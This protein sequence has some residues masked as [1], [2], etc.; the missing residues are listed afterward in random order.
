MKSVDSRG[1]GME[2]IASSAEY[3]VKLQEHLNE[4][5]EGTAFKGS[6]RCAQ[7]LQ[8]I[9]EQALQQ[10]FDCLKERM[11]GATIFGR[12]LSYDTGEDA[13]VR[14]TA[15]DVRK[16]LLQH[17]GKNGNASAFRI[18]LPLGTYIPEI[19]YIEAPLVVQEP[20]QRLN[21]TIEELKTPGVEEELS[22]KEEGS[23]K[24]SAADNGSGIRS[25][26]KLWFRLFLGSLVLLL[27][28]IL[29][30]VLPSFPRG[31]SA[32]KISVLPWSV[33][34]DSPRDLQLITSD[35]NIAEIQNIAGMPISIA[36]YANHNYIPTPNHLTQEQENMLLNV[37]KGDKS[38]AV[39]TPI[40]VDIA[41]L[42]QRNSR[43]IHVHAAREIQMSDLKTDNNF[44][45][46]GSPE[47]NP[48]VTIF[49]DQLDFRFI[50]DP[51]SGSEYVKNL[52]PKPNEQAIYQPTTNL[53]TTKEWVNGNRDIIGDSYGIMAFVQ[54]PDQTGHALLLSGVN[55][56]GTEAV[57]K[58]ATDEVRLR[59]VLRNCGMQEGSA[60]QHFQILLH[61]KTLA[62]SSSHVS[63]VACH[64][65]QN[66]GRI[67]P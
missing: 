45:F 58:L 51:K 2:Q 38:A 12:E 36:D 10:N 52:R 8:Y 55:K 13:I 3:R 14:V 59:E 18:S 53:R 22:P 60:V 42:A 67:A 47:S 30:I 19:T 31:K 66:S 37:L 25:R 20:V 65:L 32:A 57:G 17:Y 63:V 27:S 7:F 11:I 34:F 64:L 39:D 23:S 43:P 15:S 26:E 49:T 62:G 33:F 54:N 1:I 16:R 61:L 41:E 46:L 21:P 28:A 29:Y 56:E 35:P 44:I 4:I 50:F 48:W 40:A 5:V 24:D 9:V 6:N